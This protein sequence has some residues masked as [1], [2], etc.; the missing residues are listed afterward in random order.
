MVGKG[1]DSARFR[2]N[3]RLMTGVL[4]L[5]LVYTFT[6]IFY[7]VTAA[8][9]TNPDLF[10]TFGLWF[11]RDFRLGQNLRDLYLATFADTRA[12]SSTAWTE[13][14]GELLRELYER[15]SEFLESGGD[16]PER[17]E[18]L[19]LERVERRKDAARGQAA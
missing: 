9:K 19:A 11:S 4:L 18:A 15:T 7:L 16:D 3:R 13:W 2:R 14:R 5:Y 12:S 1:R 6:P 10:T 8:T 17:A